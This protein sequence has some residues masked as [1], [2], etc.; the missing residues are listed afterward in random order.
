MHWKIYA[1]GVIIANENQKKKQKKER[2]CVNRW[3]SGNT[4]C[5][6]NCTKSRR[7]GQ[8]QMIG[9]RVRVKSTE[10]TEYVKRHA[11]WIILLIDQTSC[12]SNT[13]SMFPSQRIDLRNGCLLFSLNEIVDP[14]VLSSSIVEWAFRETP[15]VLKRDRRTMEAGKEA[16]SALLFSVW[17][18]FLCN[19]RGARRLYFLRGCLL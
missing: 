4:L 18:H 5:A 3:C 9:S 12:I 6:L 17:T 14:P 13:Y 16:T 2:D 1:A 15:E 19:Y 8:W 10:T 7:K 11:I